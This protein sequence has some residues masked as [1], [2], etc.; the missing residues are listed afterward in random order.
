ML[1]SSFVLGGTDFSRIFK[2][3]THF[4]YKWNACLFVPQ[5]SNLYFSCPVSWGC[6]IHWLQLCRGVRPPIECPGYDIKQSDGEVPVMLELWGIQS[7]PSL[8]SLPDPLWPG[9]VAPDKGPIYGLNRTKP[10]F[11]HDTDIYQ[12]RE[13]NTAAV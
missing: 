9:V 6:R 8:P 12:Y 7:T 1:G 5:P 11:L 3:F 4:P 10:F 13:G 2:S